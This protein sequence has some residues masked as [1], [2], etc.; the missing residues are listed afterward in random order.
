MLLCALIEK[1]LESQSV[2]KNKAMMGPYLDVFV[3]ITTILLTNCFQ[4]NYKDTVN[5]TAKNTEY[6][7]HHIAICA[8]SL[9]GQ[10]IFE[11]TP[12]TRLKC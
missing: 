10:K 12:C 7:E 8:L 2:H 11:S 5:T 3:V 9:Y 6:E 1:T 4:Y